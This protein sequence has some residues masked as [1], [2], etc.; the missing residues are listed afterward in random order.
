MLRPAT[1]LIERHNTAVTVRVGKKWSDKPY[2]IRPFD[3]MLSE[4][5]DPENAPELFRVRERMRSWRFYDHFRT[6]AGAPARGSHIGTRTPVLGHDGADLAAALQ[7]IREIGD[8]QALAETIDEAFPGS[9]IQIVA[10]TAASTSSCASRACPVRSAPRNCPTA[11]CAT[12]SWPP[13]CSPRG[14]RNCSSSRAGDQPAPGAPAAAGRSDRLGGAARPDHRRLALGGPDRRDRPGRFCAPHRR[15]YSRPRERPW[16]DTGAR[17]RA[18]RR[19]AVALAEA[20]GGHVVRREAVQRD[21]HHP[22]RDHGPARHHPG[23]PR[24][25]RTQVARARLGRP[26]RACW[27]RSA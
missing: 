2:P 26:G 4:S 6:D 14:R 9:R 5:A 3:S 24:P 10:T 20:V 11:R 16:R 22:V 13:P 17:P 7:T 15:H 27:S 25:G 1:A 18:A 8:G 23:V 21:V 19:A 12:C